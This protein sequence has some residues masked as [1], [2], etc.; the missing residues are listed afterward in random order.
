MLHAYAAYS[1][2]SLKAT[3]GGGG[4]GSTLSNGVAVPLSGGQGSAVTYTIAVPAGVTT[5][6]IQLSGGT[7]DADLYV[8]RGSAPT[9]TTY[10]YRPYLDGNN[11][12][13]SVAAP[14]SGTWYVM[15]RGY[16]AYSDASLVATW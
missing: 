4:G 3:W 9:T 15:V 8:R 16:A 13:V 11:E 7:G 10:D 2:V 12:T 14:A 6:N 5:L 1:G